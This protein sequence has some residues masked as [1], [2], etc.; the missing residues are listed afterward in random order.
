MTRCVP[1]TPRLSA[2]RGAIRLGLLALLAGAGLRLAVADPEFGPAAAHW[3]PGAA[4]ASSAPPGRSSAA[5]PRRAAAVASSTAPAASLPTRGAGPSLP[6]PPSAPCR[7]AA[8]GADSTCDD[9]GRL[10][11]RTVILPAG[12]VMAAYPPRRIVAG[13]QAPY[14]FSVEGQWPDGLGIDPY[15]QISGQPNRV[16]RHLFTLV[17]VDSSSPPLL[18]RQSFSLWVEPAAKPAV[19]AVVASAPASQPPQVLTRVPLADA[20][21]LPA[22][23]GQIASYLLLA[24]ELDDLLKPPP[25]SEAAANAEP[26][27]TASGAAASA[28]AAAS[29][30]APRY[31][32]PPDPVADAEQLRGIV[33]P[34]LGVDFPTRGLFE[35][36][37]D[38]RRCA[39]YVDLIRAAARNQ[40][41]LVNSQCPPD[42]VPP[43]D[44]ATGVES[45]LKTAPPAKSAGSAPSA[46]D[47]LSLPALHEQLLPAD[48]KAAL[49][50]R[51][52]KRHALVDARPVVWTDDGCGCVSNAVVE[53][54]YGFYPFWQAETDLPQKLRFSLLNRIGF[55]G[56]QLGDD[57][58]F[59]IAANATVDSAPFV[60]TARRFGTQVDLVI[61]RSDWTALL[62]LS[63][64]RLLDFQK[65]AAQAAVR[66][67]DAPLSD[68]MTRAR[69]W[70]L[71]FWNDP[72]QMFDGLTVFFDHLP[73]DTEG[74]SRFRA[75]FI[76]FARALVDEMKESGRDH[77]LNFVVEDRSIASDGAYSFKELKDTLDLAQ[78]PEQTASSSFWSL[79]QW[80]A[81]KPHKR[82]SI[83]WLVLTSEP[84]ARAMKDL[85]ASID[86]SGALRGDARVEFLKSV[87]PVLTHVG[88]QASAPAAGSPDQ[89]KD[90]LAYARWSF[91]GVGF[92][93]LPQSDSQMGRQFNTLLSQVFA[94]P[95]AGVASA[96]SL[97][98]CRWI[99]PNRTALR[100][101]FNALIVIGLIAF[102]LYSEVDRIRRIGQ[103][104]VIALWLIGLATLVVALALLSCDPAL[105]ALS[106]SNIP[107]VALLVVAV[108]LGLHYSFK[109]RIPLP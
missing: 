24:E 53:Q 38:A 83:H 63:P 109:P 20:E 103:R 5:A 62:G 40:K 106:D 72:T 59:L 35:S 101:L 41:V 104:I 96:E 58:Q 44:P 22:T 102:G 9:G 76:G 92:W 52:E 42:A 16:G 39:L 51:A 25:P 107:L 82:V 94:P 67:V 23:P 50:D 31:R 64:S 105:A 95:S 80:A 11:F 108:G 97:G 84:T 68:N 60:R 29:R 36:A 10:I 70:L 34:L 99:C 4:V 98:A 57:G 15:G 19:K 78:P 26:T 21:A 48:M 74:K 55:V 7:S 54:T 79:P 93:P 75:F 28:A 49:I 100:L 88:S 85:R 13:G 66:I 65:T 56:A 77:A 91:N 71:P 3:P 30:P 33:A 90:D 86:R 69:H 81:A 47:A 87:K 6:P 89:R 37:L 12:R 2:W 18:G 27:E 8:S 43:S 46:S 73:T 45:N 1:N 17:T 32:K 61:Q 14:R